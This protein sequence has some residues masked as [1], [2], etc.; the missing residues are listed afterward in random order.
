MKKIG[1]NDPCPCGSGKK[2]KLCCAHQDFSGAANTR[3]LEDLLTAKL[4]LAIEHHQEGRI[5]QAESLYQQILDVAPGYAD[6]LNLTGLIAY[7]RGQMDRAVTLIAQAIHAKPLDQSYHYNLGVVQQ[8]QGRLEEAVACYRQALLIKPDYIEV[9]PNLGVALHS[10]N[11]LEE[12]VAC[13]RQALSIKPDYAEAYSN[14]GLAL[15][16]QGQ[17]EAAVAC[18]RQALLIKP[19]YAE[20]HC[21]LGAALKDKGQLNEAVACYQQALLVKPDFAKAYCNLGAALPDQGQLDEAILCYQQALALKPDYHEA[22]SNLLLCAQ[23]SPRY[24]PSELIAEHLRYAA[25][26]EAPLKRAWQPHLNSCEPNR[27]LKIGYVSPDFRNHS[28]AFFIEPVLANHEKSQV[29]VFCYYNNYLHDAVTDRLAAA[30][31]HWVPCIGLTDD[32]LAERIRKD[33]IDILVD[34]SVHSAQ[35]RLLTFAR[36]PAPVQVSWIGYAGTTGLDAMDYRLTDEYMDPP[37]MTEQYHSEK[38]VRL[39]T[40]YIYQA[41]AESPPVNEL[42]SLTSSQFILACLNNLAKI[43]QD[44]I[45][46][47]GRILTALPHAK[48]MLGNTDSESTKQRLID[49]FGQEGVDPERLIL[50]PKMSLMDYLALHH[51]IDLALDCFPYNGGITTCHSLWMGVPV[52]TLAGNR[53]ISRV[54]ASLMMR[55]GLAEFITHSPDQ[56]LERTLQVARNLP[57]LSQIRQTL[58]ERITSNINNDPKHLTRELE[59]AFRLMWEKW[60]N[61][62]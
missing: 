32:Q 19:D 7:Q 16:D 20:A 50:Q 55:A 9:Y 8:A 39:R 40:A 29:E 49:M 2:Y 25:Q 51:R 6:A 10:Q 54:G 23:Y 24:T 3:S 62:K 17:L 57:K 46:L 28:V 14:L 44:T 31:D 45:H 11:R 13:Y 15:K 38:L 47:W 21:N 56:Y 53:S 42:P 43:N 26:F 52:I 22:Y 1:R 18:Y 41:P 48:L 30:A 59:T 58:G 36:K 4:R 37:G 60:C 12:A 35:H 33:G 61:D 34:L 27:P 5:A